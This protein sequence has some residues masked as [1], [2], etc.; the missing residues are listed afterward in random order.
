MRLS[1]RLVLAALAVASLSVGSAPAQQAGDAQGSAPSPPPGAEMRRAPPPSLDLDLQVVLEPR[2][3]ELLKAVSRRLADAKTMNFTAV[4][5]YESLARTGEPLAY[6]TRSEVTVERPDKLRVI[7]PAD[8]PR[9]EFYYDGKQMMAY[10]PA[11]DLVAVADA[12]PTIDATLKAAFTTAGIYF[13]FTDFIVAD[14]YRDVADDLKLA[15]VVGQSQ[16]VGGTTTDIVAFV[17]PRAQVELWIDEKEK[18][19]LMA[20]ATFFNEPYR[21]RHVIEF[22]NWQLDKPVP[23]DAFHS[24]AAAQAKHIE[25]AIPASG[26]SQPK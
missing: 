8:G 13:P 26:S 9:S 15:F 25:F 6:M 10:E 24:A 23:A 21:Y 1:F 4:T 16:V 5:T 14:P 19:P 3:I 18:L 17:D 11:A 12:P 22:S 7:T 20:R 2:A